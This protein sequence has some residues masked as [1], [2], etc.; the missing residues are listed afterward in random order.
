[1]NCWEYKKCGREK[2]GSNSEEL[3]VCPAYPN[4]GKS[5]ATVAGTMCNGKIQGTF[6]K[7][8]ADCMECDFFKSRYYQL[9][10]IKLC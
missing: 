4:H 8:V 7:K 10:D 1:M 5:C 6:A 2:G 3:G 9:Y